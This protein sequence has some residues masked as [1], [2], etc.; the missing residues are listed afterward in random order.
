MT[1][2]IQL[3]VPIKPDI[4]RSYEATA[5]SQRWP[6][7]E[8][9]DPPSGASGL[10]AQASTASSFALDFSAYAHVIRQAEGRRRPRDSE[11]PS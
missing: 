11:V 4:P 7:Q 8:S 3:G 2:V 9:S 6:Q 5:L 10:G 1:A